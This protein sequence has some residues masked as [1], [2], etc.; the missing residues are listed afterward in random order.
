MGR[1]RILG[2]V[3]KMSCAFSLTSP[4]GLLQVNGSMELPPLLP[5]RSSE[6]TSLSF[7]IL[8]QMA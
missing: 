5:V 4:L 7:G 6:E 3:G 2:K 8:S 1:E